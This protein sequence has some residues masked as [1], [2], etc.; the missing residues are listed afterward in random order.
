MNAGCLLEASRFTEHLT[1][2]EIRMSLCNQQ[3][4]L[5][6]QVPSSARNIQRVLKLEGL[7]AGSPF[8]GL[9]PSGNL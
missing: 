1:R 6:F 4:K 2:L 3:W 9:L 5:V 8:Q 7:A